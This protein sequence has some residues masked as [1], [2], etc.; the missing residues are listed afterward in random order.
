MGTAPPTTTKGQTCPQATGATTL[1]I[2]KI[3]NHVATIDKMA[4]HDAS[5]QDTWA[6]RCSPPMAA[7]VAEL[8]TNPPNKPDKANPARAPNKR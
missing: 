7:I 1:A 4:A 8:D 3:C 2:N 5:R 6:L